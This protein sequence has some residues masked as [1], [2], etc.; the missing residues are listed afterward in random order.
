MTQ[1]D[2]RACPDCN[3]NNKNRIDKH[4]G[5]RPSPNERARHLFAFCGL[6][7]CAQVSSA[8]L[9]RAADWF[10]GSVAKLL[11]LQVQSLRSGSNR[12]E[13]NDKSFESIDWL[14]V[15]RRRD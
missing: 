7:S 15:L 1:R 11:S 2:L 13:S 9:S 10:I 6:L 4:N 8:Q 5:R 3:G 14:L 12:S